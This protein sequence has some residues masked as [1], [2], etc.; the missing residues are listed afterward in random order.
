MAM[1]VIGFAGVA[2]CQCFSLG[3]TK[4]RRR[5]DFLNRPAFTLR[6]AKTG[7]D[8]QRLDLVMRVPRC[9]CTRGESYARATHTRRPRSF[10]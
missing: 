5:P 6:P 3:A 4:R 2:P 9:A 8:D 7:R 1:C 10:K